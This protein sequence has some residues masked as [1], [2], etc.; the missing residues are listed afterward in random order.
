MAKDSGTYYLKLNGTQSCA[1]LDTVRVYY[2]P[3]PKA[4]AGPDTILCRNQTYTMQGAGGISYLCRNLLNIYLLPL[5]RMP[6]R[7]CLNTQ[8]Y[9]L[10]V[11]NT[12][13]CKD[14]SKV[15]LKVRPILQL[16]GSA[17]NASVCYGQNVLLSAKEQE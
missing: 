7:H 5:T 13:G 11:S 3:L 2:Y 6:R 1:A 16:K 9:T 12:H 17:D 14:S 15:M 4:T 10:I 8:Q